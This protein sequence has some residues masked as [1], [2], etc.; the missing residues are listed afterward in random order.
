MTFF[1][2]LNKKLAGISDKQEAKQINESAVA[3]AGYSAKAARAGKDIGKPGK[4]FAQIAKSA[5]E[6]YGSK[7]RG[8]KVAGA[9]LAK[10]RAK[11][12]VEEGMV[13]TIKQ[14]AQSALQ[15]ISQTLGHG[16]D[17]DMIRDLQ[18]KAG[19]P[20]TGKVQPQPQ[21][22]QPQGQKP[23]AEDD[24]EE[25]NK[26]TD[27]LMKARA[28][29]VKKADLDGDG[30]METVRE[31]AKPDFL[32][33][34]KDGNK[35]E[36]FKKAVA[37]KKKGNK[38]EE[39]DEGWD[40]MLKDVEKR[41]S[42]MKPG[43]KIQ[44]HKGEIEKTA[45]GIRHTR[46]YDPKTGE[47]DSDDDKPTG[48]KRGRGRPKKDKAPERVTS[49][50]YKHKGGRKMSK[51]EIEEAIAT[52]EGHGYAVSRL[53]ELSPETIASYQKKAYPQAA[54]TGPKSDQRAAGVARSLSRPTSEGEQELD[55]KAV[56]KQQQK[57][58]GMVHAMQ[59]GE[60]IPGASK[61]LKKVAK[62]M[63]PKDVKDFAAT[64]HDGL[65][66]K[67]KKEVEET[68]VA[69]A[70]AAG[71][72]APKSKG[73]GGMTFGKGIYDSL[74]RDLEAM[75][76]ESMNVSVNMSQDE[77]GEPHKNITVSAE[78]EA[79]EQLAQLLNLAGMAGQAH[80]HDEVCSTCGSEDCG[81]NEEMV[82]ENAP[83]WPT[84]PET[85]GGDDPHLNRWAGGLNKPKET[86]QTT[87]PVV[88]RDPARGSI[89]P[90]AMAEDK[91]LGMKL[92][93]ELK[94]FKA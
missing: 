46:K 41:R 31:G 1:Y 38:E 9:V 21:G 29:G 61:E 19:V 17:E 51:E 75:I 65:P 40:D 53:D 94:S 77:H 74:N 45:T 10:L 67:K 55:E 39:I 14:G 72:E 37:D 36:S 3:E 32:D 44:G 71:A 30:D 81:C 82:D 83:D 47:T 57:F 15:A 62:T 20:V 16:S 23:M 24:M 34:D 86:G 76:S 93:A 60:K 18:K 7:E 12:D 52:L 2:D 11:E 63:K 4:A 13:D 88:N 64:K 54:T 26:F 73:K 28:A 5:G 33:V 68:T 48:E 90:M 22:Q 80:G 56:S 35:K 79:A 87:I 43:E 78:G 70:V 49:K 85:T 84:E 6:R 50:A 25:G 66:K 8:E 92:Y 69:G 42:G 89:G 59:K 58:M 27:N 91:D